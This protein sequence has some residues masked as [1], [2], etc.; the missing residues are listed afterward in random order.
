MSS[1]DLAKLWQKKRDRQSDG[2]STTGASEIEQQLAALSRAVDQEN[3]ECPEPPK[4]LTTAIMK[5][6]RAIPAPARERLRLHWRYLAPIA[7][8]ATMFIIYLSQ[9]DFR[10]AGVTSGD[11]VPAMTPAIRSGGRVI[12]YNDGRVV[13]AT[14][15]VLLYLEGS[16]GAVFMMVFALS[17]IIA[18]LMRRFRLAALLFIVVTLIFLARES[19]SIW[20]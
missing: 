6:I 7:A 1:E 15:G 16:F 8:T 19:M 9:I 3:A 14:N 18:L 13:E 12:R 20:F 4:G 11:P 5:D 10:D 17:G 2:A